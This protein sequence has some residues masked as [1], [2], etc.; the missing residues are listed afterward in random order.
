MHIEQ[1]L[2]DVPRNDRCTCREKAKAEK[3]TSAGSQDASIF[4]RIFGSR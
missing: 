3:Q 2:G 1:V 4:K